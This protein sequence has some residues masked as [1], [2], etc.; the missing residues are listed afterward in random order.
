MPSMAFPVP[1]IGSFRVPSKSKGPQLQAKIPEYLS[2]LRH[3]SLSGFQVSS[4]GSWQ[5]NQTYHPAVRRA[6]TNEI[7]SKKESL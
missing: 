4:P 3:P 1:K 7:K 2:S 5:P 6:H